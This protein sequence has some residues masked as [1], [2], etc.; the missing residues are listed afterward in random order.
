[1]DS[2]VALTSFANN[3]FT[4][5]VAAVIASLILGAIGYVYRGRVRS[6]IQRLLHYAFDT[7]VTAQLT[8]VERYSEPPRA[9]LDIDTFQ[10]LRDVT[11]IDLSAESISENAI[12]V[13]SPE[14]PTTLEIRIEEC[15]NFDEGLESTPR[16]EVRIQT[17]ADLAFGYRTMDSVKAFQTLADDVASEIRDECFPTAEQPQT[18]LTGTVTSKTPYRV[19][20]LIE[21]D[22]LTLR[23]KVRDSKMELR[24]EDPRYLTQGIRKYF[25][26]L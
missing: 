12:R 7:T 16:Y 14:L 24:F 9:D 4:N 19:D 17:Y 11:G 21:D 22:E 26:P 10:R 8:W 25:N 6:R 15:H 5:V 13:R 20:T 2:V 23:A 1:M 3:V 18:F